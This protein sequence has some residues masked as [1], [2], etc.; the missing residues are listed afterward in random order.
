MSWKQQANDH[1]DALEKMLRSQL[2][3]KKR[4]LP[5]YR[6]PLKSWTVLTLL[7]LSAISSVLWTLSTMSKSSQ[8]IES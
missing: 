8:L 6:S 4:P 7:S 2:G 1:E 5:P 3:L